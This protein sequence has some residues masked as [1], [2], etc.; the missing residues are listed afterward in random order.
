MLAED[1][2]DDF[3]NKILLRGPV[4][5]VTSLKEAEADKAEAYKKSFGT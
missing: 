1:L 3:A 4:A 5:R 2:W